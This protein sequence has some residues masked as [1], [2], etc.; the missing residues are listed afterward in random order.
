[1]PLTDTA[2]FD[3]FGTILL[4]WGISAASGLRLVPVT[5]GLLLTAEFLHW[6]FCVK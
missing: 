1:M 4:A 2:A 6:L 5:A 3:Y